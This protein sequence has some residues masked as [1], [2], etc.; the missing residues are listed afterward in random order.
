MT[1]NNKVTAIA[2]S[3]LVLGMLGFFVALAA[4]LFLSPSAPAV[5]P[6]PTPTLPREV[7]DGVMESRIRTP[8][9][10][11]QNFQFRV[12]G[13]GQVLADERAEQVE[14]VICF[15]LSF[16]YANLIDPGSRFRRIGENGR[17][18]DR[19]LDWTAVTE[20]LI[21]KRAGNT[22][23]ASLPNVTESEWSEHSCPG[24]YVS[25]KVALARDESAKYVL[26][27]QD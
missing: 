22:W 19:G 17:V 4:D 6:P 16:E 13:R 27:N 10:S 8:E 2:F 7:Q 12:V 21:A 24:R 26:I 14:E 20:S 15:H 5:V 11:Y 23:I 3:V 1:E 9:G 18:I 25:D